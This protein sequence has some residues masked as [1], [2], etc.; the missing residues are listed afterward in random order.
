MFPA[1]WKGSGPN[2]IHLGVGKDDRQEC[3]EPH[4]RLPTLV[5]IVK[6][7]WI[8]DLSAIMFETAS[9]SRFDRY[10]FSTILHPLVF[11]PWDTCVHPG[12]HDIWGRHIAS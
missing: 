12:H 9:A 5:E 8:C 1:D 11:N 10:C 2:T 4:S 3:E 7:P 6:T